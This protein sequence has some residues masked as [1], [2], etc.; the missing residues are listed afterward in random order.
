MPYSDDPHALPYPSDDAGL[1][2]IPTWLQNLANR[3]TNILPQ[4]GTALVPV[5][6]SSTGFLDVAFDPAFAAAPVVQLQITGTGNWRAYVTATT[7]AGFRINVVHVAGTVSTTNINVNW[8]AHP[9][10]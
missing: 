3:I 9:V 5:A 4:V 1:W 8:V 10:P 6:A 2:E 7:A